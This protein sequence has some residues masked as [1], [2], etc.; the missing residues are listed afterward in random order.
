[1]TTERLI[2]GN[3]PVNR[4]RPRRTSG[5]GGPQDVSRPRSFAQRILGDLGNNT[6]SGQRAQEQRDRLEIRSLL[7]RENFPDLFIQGTTGFTSRARPTD[8]SPFQRFLT[9]GGDARSIREEWRIE[10]NDPSVKA[11]MDLPRPD[12]EEALRPVF[13]SS[14]EYI[15]DAIVQVESIYQSERTPD[16]LKAMGMTLARD[17]LQFTGEAFEAEA[18]YISRPAAGQFFGQAFLLPS[19][20]QAAM[21]KDFGETVTGQLLTQGPTAAFE[22]A[23]GLAQFAGEEVFRPTNLL[24]FGLAAKANIPILGALDNATAAAGDALVKAVATPVAIAFRKMA[25]PALQK[26]QALAFPAIQK[27]REAIFGAIPPVPLVPPPASNPEILKRVSTPR[28]SFNLWNSIADRVKDVGYGDFRPAAM[29]ADFIDPRIYAAMA[30]S[31]VK[32]GMLI[33]AAVLDHGDNVAVT[34]MDRLHLL[35]DETSLL[36]MDDIVGVGLAAGWNTGDRHD[37]DIQRGDAQ[38]GGL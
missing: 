7:T 2:E 10:P 32:S 14:P 37:Q 31:P 6:A 18:K 26:T 38:R 16:L 13:P 15:R 19:I 33:R 21:G 5:R 12:W 36:A 11:L 23:P 17:L 27:G 4:P 22:A 3:D 9:A 34:A 20:V 29:A 30:D 1:M 24:G 28:N 35:G 25:L 8:R